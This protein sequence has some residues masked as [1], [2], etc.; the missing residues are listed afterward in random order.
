MELRHLRYF[1]SVAEE[2]SFS[3]AAD[4]LHIAQPAISRAIQELEQELGAPLLLR[5]KRSVKLTPAG[6]VLLHQV[7]VLL[8][9]CDETVRKVHRTA[10][11]QEGELR[12]GYIGPPTQHFLSRLLGEF[13]RR[14]PRVTV[15]L[16]ERTP[17]RVWEMVSR[18]RLDVGLARPVVASERV[19]L[20]KLLLRKEALCAAVPHDHP[21]AQQ[22]K[23]HWSQL[24]GQPLI[25]LARRE[26]VGLHDRILTRCHEAGF[27]P[28]LSHTPSVIGAVLIYAEAGAG[29]GVV[30]DSME[31]LDFRRQLVFKPLHPLGTV[32]LVMVWSDKDNNPAALAFRTLV[33][34]WMTSGLL[35][36]AQSPVSVPVVTPS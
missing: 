18:D 3:K 5:T 1:Q 28:R 7:G 13:A 8:G 36:E 16:E 27:S 24:Q 32:D 22:R 19:G 20:Q 10:E 17:E 14:Y 12:L 35:W 9:L 11:G 23:V 6:L 21:L 31:C 33:Q 15:T 2:L 26:G 29:V 25:V 30:P 34:E 4:K